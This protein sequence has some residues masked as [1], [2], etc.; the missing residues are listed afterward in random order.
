MRGCV[1]PNRWTSFRAGVERGR[2]S[3]A[4]DIGIDV[5]GGTGDLLGAAEVVVEI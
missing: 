5:D 3:G 2:E 4:I 1:E